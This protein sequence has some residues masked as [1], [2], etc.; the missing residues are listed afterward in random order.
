MYV[1][2]IN[3]FNDSDRF[4][5]NKT[6]IYNMIFI[7]ILLEILLLLTLIKKDI[8]YQNIITFIDSKN[9]CIYVEKDYLNSIKDKKK[10][11][12]NDID[13]EYNIEKIEEKND[14]Y[15]V[16]ISFDIEL[17][18]NE[19][20]YKIFMGKEKLIEYFIRIIKKNK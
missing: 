4:I 9:A 7:I 14:I 17:K 11:I 20:Y 6:F 15:F 16:Y 12:I 3:L 19:D 10:L 5:F 18:I 8:Y 13:Y 1:K 2:K